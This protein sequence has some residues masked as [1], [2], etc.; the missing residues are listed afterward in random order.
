M[1]IQICAILYVFMLVAHIPEQ[2]IVVEPAQIQSK[3]E[4]DI[5]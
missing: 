3:L 4:R 2:T 5:C 1:G